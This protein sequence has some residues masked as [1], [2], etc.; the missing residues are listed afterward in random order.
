MNSCIPRCTIAHLKGDLMPA[1]WSWRRFKFSLNDKKRTFAAINL[2]Q[3]EFQE[4][5]HIQG[6]RNIILFK[7][8]PLSSLVLGNGFLNQTNIYHWFMN[9]VSLHRWFL[10]IMKLLKW[11]LCCFMCLQICFPLFYD[12]YLFI[13]LDLL[14][15]SLFVQ[16]L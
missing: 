1:R 14:S 2:D 16:P 6:R 8:V 11:L 3:I 9:C 12:N 13:P 7:R 4:P 15:L 5:G 10:E